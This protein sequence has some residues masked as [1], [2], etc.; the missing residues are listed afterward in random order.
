MPQ[1]AALVHP[2]RRR[3]LGE[4]SAI[5]ETATAVVGD[6][7]RARSLPF[8]DVARWC[9]EVGGV[10]PRLELAALRHARDIVDRDALVDD[11]VA[12]LRG[13][14]VHA[15]ELLPT[16]VA[17]GGVPRVLATLGLDD[18]EPPADAITRLM[19]PRIARFYWQR[20]R[21]YVAWTASCRWPG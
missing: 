5:V 3:A 8:E 16:L 21:A 6:A 12:A 15:G 13:R 2:R 19:P 17:R 1:P 14:L 4:L 10:D 7:A 9:A 18:V 20:L 11:V